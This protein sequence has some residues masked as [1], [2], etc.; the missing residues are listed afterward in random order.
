M[1][2]GRT[3]GP[4]DARATVVLCHGFGADEHDLIPLTSSLSTATSLRFV[5]PRAPH[6]FPSGW[7]AGRAWFPDSEAELAGFVTGEMFAHLDQVD[8]PALTDAGTML[9][10][11]V[12]AVEG[13]GGR[14]RLLVGG[15]SQG[16]MV[17]CEAM[18]AAGLRADGLIVLSGAL[19]AAARWRSLA[20]A[21]PL[22]GVSVF[23]AHGEADPVLPF[24]SGRLLGETL[25][26]A[27]AA[28][29][30][31]RFA[32]GHGIAPEVLDKLSVWIDAA[33]AAPP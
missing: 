15:F 22:S 11:T 33:C 16:A 21:R 5:F 1:L 8:P 4:A 13:V 29:T 31:V 24:E 17:A 10:S 25:E 20:A 27:G 18:L 6:A 32:G 2:E 19:I 14:Q 3:V 23:Q 28:P 9:A 7:G 30:F 12:R 26:F